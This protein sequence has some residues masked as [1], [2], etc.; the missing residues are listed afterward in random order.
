MPKQSCQSNIYRIAAGLGRVTY[1]HKCLEHMYDLWETF[2][3][4]VSIFTTIYIYKRHKLHLIFQKV[5]AK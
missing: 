4:D 5:K 3:F 1:Q 2:G